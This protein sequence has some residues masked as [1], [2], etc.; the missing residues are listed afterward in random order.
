MNAPTNVRLME[1]NGVKY[2]VLPYDDYL[3]LSR[4]ELVKQTRGI[5][6]QIVGEVMLQQVNPVLAWRRYLSLTQAELA[7]RMG[8]SQPALAQIENASRPRKV[9]LKKVAQALGLQIE[10]LLF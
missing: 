8:I 9:T 2:A 1:E 3:A 10:Q 6:H 4:F 5:P 7:A